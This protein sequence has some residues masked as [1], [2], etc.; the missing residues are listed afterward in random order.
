[1]QCG[2]ALS[3]KLLQR[4]LQFDHFRAVRF[5]YQ[6]YF[7]TPNNQVDLHAVMRGGDEN[8]KL[9]LDQFMQQFFTSLIELVR[10][11]R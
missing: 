6:M 8:E 1:M 2:V 10:N 7:N 9:A 4:P 5:D 3:P 11:Y